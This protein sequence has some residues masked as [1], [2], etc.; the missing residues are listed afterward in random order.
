MATRDFSGEYFRFGTQYYVSG[1]VATAL[2]L[3]PVPGNLFHHAIE[4]FLKGDLCR[5]L[6][7]A[8]LKDFHHNLKCLWTAFKHKHKDPALA[9][10]DARIK[11]L[12]KFEAIRYPDRIATKGMYATISVGRWDRQPAVFPGGHTPPGYHLV[13]QDI[14]E[15]VGVIFKKA[16]MNP[17]F[18][19]GSLTSDARSALCRDNATF[20]P[21]AVT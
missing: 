18:F 20:G 21:G 10:F 15:L 3:L 16:S 8:E 1:R 6:S 14:D 17:A 9:T 19:F 7:A 2:G 12:H 5:A 4:L 13:V 11:A